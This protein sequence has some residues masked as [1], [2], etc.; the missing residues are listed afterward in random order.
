MN[1][2]DDRRH[3]GQYDELELATARTLKTSSSKSTDNSFKC[4]L[5]GRYCWRRLGGKAICL[6][7]L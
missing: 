4:A 2:V 3:D 1:N 7:D 5:D 6:F